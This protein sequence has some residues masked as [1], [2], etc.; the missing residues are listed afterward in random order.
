VNP[1]TIRVVR[2]PIVALVIVAAFVAVAG[3]GTYR[4]AR[5]L[6]GWSAVAP[7]SEAF[8]VEIEEATV[9]RVDVGDS[10]VELASDLLGMFGATLVV[11]PSTQIQLSGAPAELK[12]LPAG[13]KVRAAYVWK[14][15]F[16]IA[17]L[18]AADDVPA[19]AKGAVTR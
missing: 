19:A 3:Y 2:G 11:T 1:R 15:G 7:K 9:R 8:R 16:K 14:D 10:K 18:I 12:D 5:H 13:A 17:H 6:F 4:V